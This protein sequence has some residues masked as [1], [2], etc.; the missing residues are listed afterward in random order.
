MEG[1]RYVYVTNEA[2]TKHNIIHETL[3]AIG[4]M[5]DGSGFNES[6]TEALAQ[7]FDDLINAHRYDGTNDPSTSYINGYQDGVNALNALLEMNIDGFGYSDIVDTY[8]ENDWTTKL[9]KKENIKKAIDAVMGEGYFDNTLYPAFDKV[10]DFPSVSDNDRN[11]IS[12][13]IVNVINDIADKTGGAAFSTHQTI[14]EIPLE[15]AFPITEIDPIDNK[16]LN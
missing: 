12:Q 11:K 8:M 16:P 15:D 4:S 9:E 2:A 13:D 10:K 5:G 6:V 3:H 14:E 7:R 1:K